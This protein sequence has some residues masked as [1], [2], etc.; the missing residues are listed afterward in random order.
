MPNKGLEHSNLNK[1]EAQRRRSQSTSNESGMENA[2]P[3]HSP[4][5]SILALQKTR[6]NAAVLRMLA[7]RVPGGRI[8][9]RPGYLVD[10]TFLG[11]SC[12]GG[13]N[14]IMKARLQAV[15]AD[16][17]ATFDG[18]PVDQKVN[19]I[20][21]DPA[22]T[23]REWSGIRQPHGCWHPRGGKHSSGSACDINYN[24]NPYIAT[25]TQGTD[26]RGNPTTTY[27]GEA[28]GSG[29][30][31]QR[32]AATDVYD[33]ARAFIGASQDRADVGRRQQGEFDG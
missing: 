6:G 31:T 16:L 5:S 2:I 19:P 8:Q 26:R 3:D 27:G 32:H 30:Q 20:T 12:A 17:Q 7:D 14:P 25:R 21:G 33:R 23:L 22:T 18:L 9:R 24:T 29:L 11:W 13:V 4:Q 28:A 15:Q 1:D 10:F